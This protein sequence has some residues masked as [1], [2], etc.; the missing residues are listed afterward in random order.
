M[1][2]P[3]AG[4]VVPAEDLP[5]VVNESKAGRVEFRVDKTANVHVPIGKVSFDQKKL[6]D[7]MAALMEAI[8]K[9]R[10]AAAKGTYIKRVTLTS[11][12]GPGI[13]VDA[14]QSQSMEVGE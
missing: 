10:P 4:T 13:R 2:N 11:T 3:K 5:R 1:P 14:V 12:M 7:N 6:Y 8:K 9:A